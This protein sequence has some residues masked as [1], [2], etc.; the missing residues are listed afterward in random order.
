[1][2]VRQAQQAMQ[3]AAVAQVNLRSFQLALPDV[4]KPGLELTR[5]A[6]VS[7]TPLIRTGA[8]LPRTR[9]RIADL[10]RSTNTRSTRNN[11]GNS[12]ISSRTTNPRS[13]PSVISGF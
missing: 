3:Q 10:G 1:M 6:S 2:A 7:G 5:P 8:A 11:S 13:A 12:W 9:N 4:F